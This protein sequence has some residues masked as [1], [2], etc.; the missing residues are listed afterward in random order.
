MRPKAIKVIIAVVLL[1]VIYT[2]V[3]F[4]SVQPIGALPN[5]ITLL[6]WRHSG[7][8]FFNSPDAMSMKVT[9]GVSLMSRAMAIAAG[10]KDR[11]IMRLPYID[12]FY[13]LSTGG[14]KFDR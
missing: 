9:G 6:V 8:P 2:Q 4:Y 13:L 7:E 14:Q 1:V 11:I 3:G 5:G 12:T 10:P